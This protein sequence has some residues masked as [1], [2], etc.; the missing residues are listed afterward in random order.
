MELIKTDDYDGEKE[1]SVEIPVLG[2]VA[3]GRPVMAIENMDGS[4]KLHR[5]FLKTNG[6]YFALQV[7]GDS[8]EE[9]GIMNGDTAVIEHCDRVRNGQIA[10][11]MLEDSVTLKRFY[12][13][14]T[15]IKLQPENSKYSPIY[16]TGDVSILGKLIFIFR[17]Y[18]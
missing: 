14:S 13:E 1:D 9:A 2:T 6:K 11:V 15:R 10:V 8:M 3:A 18:D 12:R 17:S 4:I 7:K 5:S 16:C